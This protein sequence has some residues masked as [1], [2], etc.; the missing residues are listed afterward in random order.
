MFGHLLGWYTMHLRGLLP[1]DGILPGA[2]FTCILLYWQRYCTALE[3]RASAKICGMLEQLPY[4][5]PLSGTTIKHRTTL[6]GYVFAET[7]I[8]NR[9]RNLLNSNTSSTCPHNMVNFGL[10]T[11]EI[12]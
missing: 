1:H 9:K 5:G 11:T 7:C 10:L 12:C 3:Q 6:S 4:Y 8:D 2:K